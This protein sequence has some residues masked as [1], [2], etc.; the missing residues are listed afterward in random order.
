LDIQN[1]RSTPERRSGELL[2]ERVKRAEVVDVLR[3]YGPN[4]AERLIYADRQPP[5]PEFVRRVF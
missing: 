2:A 5:F 4:G 1:A 3:R